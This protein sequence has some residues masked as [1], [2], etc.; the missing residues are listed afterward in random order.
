MIHAG[1]IEELRLKNACISIG[2]FDG[3]HLGH[4]KLIADL[5]DSAIRY[6]APAV[7]LTFY[8]H[9]AVVLKRIDAPFYL[10]TPQEKA[11]Y[12]SRLGVDVLISMPFTTSL[13]NMTP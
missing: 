5:K 11:D 1:S 8:P 2:S 3:I 12:L 7:V 9:P 10:S 6:T 4:Q 13:A